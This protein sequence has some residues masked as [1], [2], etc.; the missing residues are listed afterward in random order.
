MPDF[1]RIDGGLGTHWMLPRKVNMNIRLKN[2]SE[3]ETKEVDLDAYA[4]R[5]IINDLHQP[6]TD[7]AVMLCEG[8]SINRLWYKWVVAKERK[9]YLPLIDFHLNSYEK[10]HL[11]AWQALHDAWTK[12]SDESGKAGVSQPIQWP[13][14]H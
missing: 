14:E 4:A 13:C 10:K 8:E 7:E 1:L 2:K 12:D 3:N 6:G 9:E 5:Q 11:L